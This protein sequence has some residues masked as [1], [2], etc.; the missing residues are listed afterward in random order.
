MNKDP[1]KHIRRIN[2]ILRKNRRILEGAINS[3]ISELEA[4]EL[5]TK[6]FDFNY[7][8]HTEK[9]K[10]AGIIYYCYDYG[11]V[12]EQGGRVLIVS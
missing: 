5:Q 10:S 11:Y 9:G 1:N 3:G 7:F 4:K 2:L 12:K 6:G 8:T